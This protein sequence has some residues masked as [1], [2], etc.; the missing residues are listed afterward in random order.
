MYTHGFCSRILSIVT[1]TAF[2]GGMVS[3][4][5]NISFANNTTY[6]VD[7]TLGVDGADG[8]TQ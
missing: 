8:L 5:Q 4:L 6:Y 7:A 3:P 2:V 1:L